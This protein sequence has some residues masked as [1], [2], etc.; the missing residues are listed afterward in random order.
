MRGAKPQSAIEQAIERDGIV[1]PGERLVVACSGGAD[2]IAL[3]AALAAV[4]KP[5]ELVMTLAYVHH[6]TRESAWQDECVVLRAGATFGLQV[7]VAAIAGSG[8]GEQALR[9]ARYDA[10][11]GLA[12]ETGA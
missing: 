4:A 3:V 10:L 6:G 11:A 7:R 12:H 8:E 1:R 5:M 9:N 2:S